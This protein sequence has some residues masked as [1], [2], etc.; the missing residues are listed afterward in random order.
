MTPRTL[1]SV[2]A[3][4][5]PG[6]CLL[7]GGAVDH[8]YLPALLGGVMVILVIYGLGQRRTAFANVN[9]Q[10]KQRRSFVLGGIIG[11]S[12]AI[13]GF[14][15]HSYWLAAA[16]T[17]ISIGALLQLYRTGFSGGRWRER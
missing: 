3:V 8:E 10:K 17:F 16:G 13:S 6:L 11:L 1:I 14:V 7:I 5:V 4:G 2:L 15:S 12:F 9:D